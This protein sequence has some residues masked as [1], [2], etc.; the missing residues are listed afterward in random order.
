L[1]KVYADNCARQHAVSPFRL[2]DPSKPGHRRFIALWLVD[3][4]KRIISTANVPPQQMTWYAENLLGTTPESRREVL[5]KM[6]GELATLMQERGSIVAPM[7][8]NTNLT[9]HT[10]LPAEL[11]E[12]VRQYADDETCALPMGVEEARQHRLKLMKERGAFRVNVEY[13][14]LNRSYNFCEH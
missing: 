10:K 7:D 12:M 6:P 1:K 2:V 5:A 8:D 3:P 4:N 13:E 14:W 11:M 9:Q